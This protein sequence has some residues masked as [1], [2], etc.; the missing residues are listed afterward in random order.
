MMHGHNGLTQ[1]LVLVVH[2]GLYSPPLWWVQGLWSVPRFF[3]E[4]KISCNLEMDLCPFSSCWIGPFLWCLFFSSWGAWC[5]GVAG[6]AR[7]D[8]LL[9]APRSPIPPQ[10]PPALQPAQR[11]VR[12][13]SHLLPPSASHS[14]HWWAWSQNQ[15]VTFFL[16]KTWC[17]VFEI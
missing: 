12:S 16:L 1:M 14:K 2:H 3:G 6:G 8:S 7:G 10:P 11:L 17:P 4:S 5:Q 9:G 13:T 15:W